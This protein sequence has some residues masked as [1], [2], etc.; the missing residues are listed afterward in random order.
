MTDLEF[1][2][3]EFRIERHWYMGIKHH[4]RKDLESAIVA[5]F[6]KFASDYDQMLKDTSRRWARE[7]GGK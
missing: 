7:F 6:P 3:N 1:W 4:S 2:E 5:T